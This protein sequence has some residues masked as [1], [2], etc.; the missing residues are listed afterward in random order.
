MEKEHLFKGMKI[1]LSQD[2]SHTKEHFGWNEDMDKY[3]GTI[4]KIRTIDKYNDYRIR[5]YDNTYNWS[6]KDLLP[7]E[8]NP[9]KEN[10]KPVHF[11]P[12]DLVL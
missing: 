12:K 3:K 11:D 10:L 6:F 1:M 9:V 8:T 7:I 5:C 2:C 4:Q